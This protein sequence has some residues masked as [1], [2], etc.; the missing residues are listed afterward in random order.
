[1]HRNC[2]VSEVIDEHD[3]AVYI[4]NFWKEYQRPS[5]DG[6]QAATEMLA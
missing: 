3:V 6:R 2:V 1:M 5:G 4:A